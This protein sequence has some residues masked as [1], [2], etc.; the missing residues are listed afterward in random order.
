[1]LPDCTGV[2]VGAAAGVG[3]WGLTGIIQEKVM[4]PTWNRRY[5]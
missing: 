2:D 4:K 3:E 1:V 5:G